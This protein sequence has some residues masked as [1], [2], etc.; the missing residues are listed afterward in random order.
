MFNV[1]NDQKPTQY[2]PRLETGQL[3]D[4]STFHGSGTVRTDYLLPLSFQ[5]PRYFS[6]SVSYDY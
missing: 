1:T 4:G 5:A 3:T 2:Q 6:L